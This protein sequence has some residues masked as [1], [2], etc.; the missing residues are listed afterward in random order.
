MPVSPVIVIIA[1]VLGATSA[2]QITPPIRIDSRGI[3]THRTSK[4][5]RLDI[6]RS[7]AGGVAIVGNVT[8]SGADLPAAFATDVIGNSYA[9]PPTERGQSFAVAAAQTT[10]QTSIPYAAFSNYNW[11]VETPG[12]K[13]TGTVTLSGTA[14]TGSGTAFL[15]ELSIGDTVTIGSYRALVVSVADDTN[16]VLDTSGT[17]AALSVLYNWTPSKRFKQYAASPSGPHQYNVT[18]VGGYALITLAVAPPVDPAI[19]G[20]TALGLKVY[21]V[22][23]ATVLAAGAHIME[24]TGI[25]AKQVMWVTFSG[26]QTAANRTTVSVAPLVR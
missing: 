22:T 11:L 24:H 6:R 26:I 9:T 1:D 13:C 12:Y 21:R 7:D 3:G 5:A 10:F 19:P 15:T 18:D 23:P 17:A 25:E 2:G 20:V 8:V 16:A 4:Y 14:L